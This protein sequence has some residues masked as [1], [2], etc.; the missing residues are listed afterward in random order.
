MRALSSLYVPVHESL[1]EYEGG[2]TRHIYAHTAVSVVS[3]SVLPASPA[4]WLR[5]TGDVPNHSDMLLMVYAIRWN[6][7]SASYRH[8]CFGQ[9]PV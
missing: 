4:A 3:Q 6:R 9:T 5:Y 7:R 2:W 8:L 1:R